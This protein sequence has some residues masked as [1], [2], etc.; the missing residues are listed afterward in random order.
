MR[1]FIKI[2]AFLTA[3][4]SLSNAASPTPSFDCKKATT[5]VEKAICSDETLSKLDSDMAKAYDI[6]MG[7]Y[8]LPYMNEKA[9]EEIKPYLKIIK[10]SQVEWLKQRDKCVKEKDDA[11]ALS[12]LKD[13]Y[14]SRIQ[15]FFAGYDV[16][17]GIIINQHVKCEES[18]K[19]INSENSYAYSEFYLAHPYSYDK[20]SSDEDISSKEL[21]KLISSTIPD[22]ISDP[23]NLSDKELTDLG[24]KFTN[25]TYRIKKADPDYKAPTFDGNLY[26][27]EMNTFQILGDKDNV[28]CIN[29]QKNPEN[30][31]CN[32][33]INGCPE[34]CPDEY[35][36]EHF[37]P[38]CV[39]VK[40]ESSKI[41][42]DYYSIETMK[43][44]IKKGIMP[45]I[46]YDATQTLL[47]QSL[48]GFILSGKN[49]P[50]IGYNDYV[51]NNDR[52][53]INFFSA[54]DKNNNY[55]DTYY[56][57]YGIKN[58]FFYNIYFA[59]LESEDKTGPHVK[60]GCRIPLYLF[61]DD[62]KY[63]LDEINKKARIKLGDYFSNFKELNKDIESKFTR[64]DTIDIDVLK[65]LKNAPDR[66]E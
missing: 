38:Y 10:A 46:D 7:K 49:I 45:K 30:G 15:S 39:L 14:T 11:K 54:K 29:L 2:L 62:D 1:E 42:N 43:D 9:K 13:S 55:S 48:D 6:V 36:Y 52:Y 34:D 53:D 27:Y 25:Y 32:F 12:C 65:G 3:I 17:E 57:Y 21:F 35:I 44:D 31:C 24:K 37:K 61:T 47:L 26:F 16:D 22:P 8:D 51:I 50:S 40:R 33:N 20:F 56:L 63:Y 19:W 28:I 18:A 64:F 5:K 59:T 58:N 66:E 4:I 23:K 41:P 60:L